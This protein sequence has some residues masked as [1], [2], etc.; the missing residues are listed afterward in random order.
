MKKSLESFVDLQEALTEFDPY[1]Q[2]AHSVEIR[3]W[4]ENDWT[5]LK[6]SL[7]S[8][9]AQDTESQFGKMLW[10]LL[11]YGSKLE[12]EGRINFSNAIS[13][14]DHSIRLSKPYLAEGRKVDEY[15]ARK[16]WEAALM[17]GKQK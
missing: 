5:K 2:N 4:V 12:S 14:T 10:S 6:E 8:F 17:G 3:R 11:C 13:K 16:L 1:Y 7:D 15:E 9:Q